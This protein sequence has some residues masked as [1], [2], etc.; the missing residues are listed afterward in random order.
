MKLL[1]DGAHHL[2]GLLLLLKPV[3][4]VDVGQLGIVTN[5]VQAVFQV[6]DVGF[7]FGLRVD[8]VARAEVGG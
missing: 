7:G 3:L 4:K 1:G 6:L 2:Q 8:R 5:R